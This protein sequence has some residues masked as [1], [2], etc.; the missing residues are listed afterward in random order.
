MQAMEVGVG[1]GSVDL[2]SA[3][4]RCGAFLASHCVV[5]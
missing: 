5:L 2:S 1:L 3:M 4:C